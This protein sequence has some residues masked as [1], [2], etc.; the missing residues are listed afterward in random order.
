MTSLNIS[1]FFLP[2]RILFGKGAINRLPELVENLGQNI[3]FIT[4]K[5]PDRHGAIL[6]RVETCNTKYEIFTV[7]K[8]PDVQILYDCIKTARRIK[9]DVICSIGGGSVIDTGKAVSALLTNPGDLMDYLEVVGRGLQLHNSPMPFIAVP[10][11][12]GTGSEVTK[13]AVVN[14]ND[15]KIK[16]SLRSQKMFPLIAIVDP[17]LT[18]NL[19][20]DITASSG[21]D[22]FVQLVEAYTSTRANPFISSM[23]RDGVKLTS[24]SLLEAVFGG[25]FSARENMALAATLSGIALSFS[26]L[27]AVHGLSASIGGLF[28]DAPHGLL[29]ARLFPNVVRENLRQIEIKSYEA[30]L[31]AYLDVFR[32]ISGKD[33]DSPKDFP[34]W[35]D[36]YIEKFP[37]CKL[38]EY[39]IKESDFPEIVKRAKK[40]NSMKTNPVL[41]DD[42]SLRNIL[43]SSL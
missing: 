25:D 2:T 5:D 28:P 10:T 29:C 4:G 1:D 15:L 26:G 30:G 42:E 18:I 20:T 8:E 3:L 31:K 27:G 23:I 33:E 13:N 22:A 14:I 43:L 37:I 16:V 6:R 36:D 40:A 9:P 38:T 34:L 17:E 24:S 41:L 12:S 7:E 35:L 19:P 11:T 21:M 39:G 32:I